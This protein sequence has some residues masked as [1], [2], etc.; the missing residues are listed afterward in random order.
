MIHWTDVITGFTAPIIWSLFWAAVGESA[1]RARNAFLRALRNRDPFLA[2]MLWMWI[3]IA[4]WATVLNPIWHS[5]SYAGGSAASFTVALTIRLWR[6]N[7][8]K[9]EALIGAKSRALRDA[10]T[11]RMP[12][13]TPQGAS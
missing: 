4:G 7:R 3:L 8:R 2:E 13:P 12:Q 5:Y 10:L 11:A 1:K 6:K 9:I